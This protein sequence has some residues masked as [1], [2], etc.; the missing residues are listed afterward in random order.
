MGPVRNVD[1]LMAVGHGYQRAMILFAAL[2]LGV[3]R[4]LAAGGCDASALARRVGAAPGKLSILLD[5][6]A[7]GGRV[8]IQEFLLAEGKTSPPGPVF[9]SVHMAAVTEGGRAYTAR[10]IAAMMKTAGFRKI[11]ADRPDSR[12]V[13]ILRAFR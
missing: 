9:F 10:E 11:S 12:G 2:K 13:G 1:D 6:L 3:F 7:P 4:G 8:A 5:A